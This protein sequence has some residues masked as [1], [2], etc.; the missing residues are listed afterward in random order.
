MGG[1]VSI[2]DISS[3]SNLTLPYWALLVFEFSSWKDRQSLV[4][5]NKII[6]NSCQTGS[7]YRFMCKILSSQNM[8][9][10]PSTL[11]SG[12]T[13]K[14]L[15]VELHKIRGLWNSSERN[16]EVIALSNESDS[17]LRFK[18]SVYARF[19]PSDNLH[20]DNDD[21]DDADHLEKENKKNASNSMK[22]NDFEKAGDNDIAAD[23]S[24]FDTSNSLQEVT[25]PLH[26]RLAMIRMSHNL[27]SN[28]KALKIL[29][30][31]GGWFHDKWVNID[32]QDKRSKN[33]VSLMVHSNHPKPGIANKKAEK[34]LAGLQ[35]I[36]PVTG[37]VVVIAPDVGLRQF[38]FDGVFHLEASQSTVYDGVAKKLVV[39]FLNGFNATAIVYGQTGSGKT[40]SMFGKDEKVISSEYKGIIPRACDEIFTAVHD[41]QIVN[42]I[43]ARIGISYVEIFG[44]HVSDLLRMGARCGHSKVAAQ[45]YVLNGAAE[46]I[47]SNMSD[48]EEILRI[49]EQ[50]KRRAAT[51]MNDRST[52]AH[53]IF[54]VTLLQS[55]PDS[56]MTIQSRLFLADL[57]GSE[58]V[59]KSQV[60]AGIHRL[61]ADAQFSL[62]FE[63]GDR[64]REAVNIN[65]GL[66]ALKKCI[67]SLNNRSIYTPYKDSKLTMLLS[68]GLGGNSKT[69]VIV[70]SNT[71]P[72]HLSETIAT[73]RFGEK[74]SQV[75]NEAKNNASMLANVLANLDQQIQDLQNVILAKERWQ[76]REER[77]ADENAEEGTM[78][79]AIGVEIKKVYVVVGAEKERKTLENL[80][81]Q[82]AKFTGELVDDEQEGKK[83]RVVGFGKEYAELYGLGSGFDENAEFT[84]DNTRFAIE[85]D[86]SAIPSV[87][88]VKGGSNWIS[89]EAIKED[90]VVLEKKALKAKRSKMAYS[91]FSF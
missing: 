7:F 45:R 85:T 33:G 51:A 25:L 31:E 9:Y 57:G 22:V 38:S 2:E 56:E 12:D 42:G 14:S 58:Q 36:D 66:L 11:P 6:F 60:D 30:S 15:F 61:G 17:N 16:N 26:Q 73:L 21:N 55:I 81:L 86:V 84:V 82:R 68:E 70:C 19:R 89:G 48:V 80:L 47:V 20:K 10:V 50:Q 69:S 59:K 43:S 34:L 64:M 39:D 72:S 63:L 83:S 4:I 87:V 18:I 79:A 46:K 78:E 91:G 44:D 41:R 77:R 32:E 76:S 5:L 35:N 54:I 37:Q 49:G 75:E 65:L 28:K 62:G 27:K 90:I 3:Q 88:R 13:W 23:I 67:E 24:K 71:D 8:I 52:R 29:A 40:F 1:L 74:C 53:S